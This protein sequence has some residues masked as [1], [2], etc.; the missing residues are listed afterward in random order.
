MSAN[1]NLPMG[2]DSAAASFTANRFWDRLRTDS[3]DDAQPSL[4]IDELPFAGDQP[5][6]L[7]CVFPFKSPARPGAATALASMSVCPHSGPSCT[8]TDGLNN[9]IGRVNLRQP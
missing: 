9:A 2:K 7:S 5:V 8:E 3:G 6:E 1:P 4:P